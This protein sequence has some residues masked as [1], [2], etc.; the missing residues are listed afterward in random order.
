[1]VVL[2]CGAALGLVQWWLRLKFLRYVYD[3]G[4]AADLDVASAALRSIDRRPPD[5][6]GAAPQKSKPPA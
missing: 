5:P 3:R 4:G 1:M 6:P 2:L